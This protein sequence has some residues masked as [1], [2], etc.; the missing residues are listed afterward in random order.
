MSRARLYGAGWLPVGENVPE[1][2]LQPARISV[3]PQFRPRDDRTP[4]LP[5]MLEMRVDSKYPELLDYVFANPD[6]PKLTLWIDGVVYWLTHVDREMVKQE[7][8]D[9][10]GT[11]HVE[12]WGSG[13][14]NT[15]QA[16]LRFER[17]QL[18][19]VVEA[20]W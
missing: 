14:V 19:P 7:F 1:P 12:S 17:E 5:D 20:P 16:T 13:P 6:V 8:S 11:Y 2:V 18:I 4:T 15:R 3:V 9:S 10:H